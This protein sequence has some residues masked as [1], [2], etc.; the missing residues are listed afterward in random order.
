MICELLLLLLFA[1]PWDNDFASP[2]ICERSPRLF[3]YMLSFN[4]RDL[5]WGRLSKHIQVVLR[6]TA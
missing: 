2:S 1:M 6:V 3:A 4:L 5:V